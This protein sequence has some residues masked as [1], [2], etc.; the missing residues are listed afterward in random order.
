[1]YNYSGRSSYEKILNGKDG[2]MVRRN[3]LRE[4]VTLETRDQER[5]P[6]PLV[7]FRDRSGYSVVPVTTRLVVRTTVLDR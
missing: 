7:L 1:M 2:G 6:L 4:P 5:L 3:P